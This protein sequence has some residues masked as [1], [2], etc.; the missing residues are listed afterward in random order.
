LL[1]GVHFLFFAFYFFL[2]SAQRGHS[3]LFHFLFCI[4]STE[5]ENRTELAG[6]RI[7]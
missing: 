3:H 7:Q 1:A 5:D 2:N 4:F 6:R